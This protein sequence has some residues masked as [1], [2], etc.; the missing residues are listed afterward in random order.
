MNLL[1]PFLDSADR[2]LR[3]ALTG[4]L[5][6]AEVRRLIGGAHRLQSALS[7]PGVGPCCPH[8][9]PR[10][11][12]GLAVALLCCDAPQVRTLR[13]QGEFDSV[14]FLSELA[15]RLGA[16]AR[17]EELGPLSLDVSG[18][19]LHVEDLS[20]ANPSSRSGPCCVPARSVLPTLADGFQRLR[21]LTSL[22]L[23]LRCVD[24]ASA[25]VAAETLLPALGGC[26]ALRSLSLDLDASFAC[27]GLLM[28]GLASLLEGLGAWRRLEHLSLGYLWWTEASDEVVL[29]MRTALQ[30]LEGSIRSLAIR[31]PQDQELGAL[32]V[33]ST[34]VIDGVAQGVE[35]VSVVEAW[36]EDGTGLPALG[37]ALGACERL[38]RID[39][40]GVLP[41]GFDRTGFVA[42]V[43]SEAVKTG[44]PRGAKR[45][46]AEVRFG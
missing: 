8:L 10:T 20:S 19:L 1:E 7:A 16:F 46:S 13:P 11:G 40:L 18:E 12:T 24:V 32:D 21:Q 42:S 35:E 36:G 37:E 27:G 15:A 34:A 14:V 6:A 39:L 2:G 29:Q 28:G 17:L 22:T 33:A 44:G 38:R 45:A 9:R 43:R 30:A 5:V 41:A 26:C 3:G 25:R 31:Y 23:T 4:C